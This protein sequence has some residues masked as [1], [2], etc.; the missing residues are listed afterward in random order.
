MSNEY[1]LK[2]KK[3]KREGKTKTNKKKTNLFRRKEYV[4]TWGILDQSFYLKQ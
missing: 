1:F 3:D 2:N 4:K